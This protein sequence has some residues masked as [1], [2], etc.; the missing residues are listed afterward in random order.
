MDFIF[1]LNHMTLGNT[2]YHHN[3]TSDYERL[4]GFFEAIKEK[5]KGTVFDLGTG[6]GV[7]SSW[8]A[9]YADCVVAVELNRSTSK[10]AKKILKPSTTL[11]WC[12]LMQVNINSVPRQML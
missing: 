10:I 9:P 12:M 4:A 7:L 3:L 5:S 2:P 1:I 8:A 6:S 11:Q